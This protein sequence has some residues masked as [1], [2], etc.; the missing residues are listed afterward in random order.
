MRGSQTKDVSGNQPQGED[1]LKGSLGGI[2]RN[3]QEAVTGTD[4]PYNQ[5]GD[6]PIT[7]GV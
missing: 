6:R 5:T 2:G 4:H 7:S 1:S 3:R